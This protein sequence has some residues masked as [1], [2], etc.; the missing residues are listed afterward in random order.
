VIRELG[1]ITAEGQIIA[2]M[3]GVC[4]VKDVQRGRWLGG[5]VSTE[6]KDGKVSLAI[7]PVEYI[8]PEEQETGQA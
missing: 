1:V 4:V 6:Y 5:L 8:K 2:R 7:L 3:Y